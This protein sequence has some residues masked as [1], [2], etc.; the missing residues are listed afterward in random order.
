MDIEDNNINKGL[1]Q[2]G[3]TYGQ[4]RPKGSKNKKTIVKESLERLN[5]VGITPLET[6]NEILSSL[7][8][9]SETSI[10]QKI[11][12]LGV[13]TGLLKYEL[14]TRSE[15]IKYDELLTENEELKQK[16]KELTDSKET[17]FTGSPQD[18]LEE[19]KK[20]EK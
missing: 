7:L 19:L 8:N 10:D 20:E 11:K 6:T 12:L 16:N 14:L 15:E 3:N 17:Y 5:E 13:T 2:K 1:F 18:L 4:G 9:N